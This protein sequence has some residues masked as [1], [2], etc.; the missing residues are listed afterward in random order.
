MVIMKKKLEV[1]RVTW[2]DLKIPRLR[3]NTHSDTQ[4]WKKFLHIETN[5]YI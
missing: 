5:I 4:Y 3:R 2:M 1:Q